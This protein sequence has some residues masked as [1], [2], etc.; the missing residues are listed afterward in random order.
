MTGSL[1]V[2]Y[3]LNSQLN[4]KANIGRGYRSP[5]ITE[6]AANGLDP[7]AHIVYRGNRG[8][9]PEFSLQEDVALAGEYPGLSFEVEGFHNSIQGYIYEDQ[10][11]DAN[12]NPVVIIRDLAYQDHL[13]RLQYFE[14]YAASPNGRSGLYNMGRN[15]CLKV[16]RSF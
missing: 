11:V 10:E 12:G 4:L 5:N 3:A 8:F 6:I 14:Y 2:C 1:G 13:S 16:I 7:G 15:A 9:R